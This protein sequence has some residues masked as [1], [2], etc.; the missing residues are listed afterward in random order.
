M[1]FNHS[2]NPWPACIKV[3]DPMMIVP[4]FICTSPAICTKETQENINKP[5]KKH[6]FKKIRGSTPGVRIIFLLI[7]PTTTKK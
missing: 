1:A 3:D 5:Q 7:K 6:T 2:G 4:D